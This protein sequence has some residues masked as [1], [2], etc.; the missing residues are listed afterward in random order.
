MSGKRTPP[1]KL[2]AAWGLFALCIIGTITLVAL[3]HGWLGWSESLGPDDMHEIFASALL[4]L[5]FSVSLGYLTAYAWFRH[6]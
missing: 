6:R 2:R 5:G 4:C 1:W 3:A